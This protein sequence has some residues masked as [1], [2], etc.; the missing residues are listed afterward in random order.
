MT[1]A[2]FIAGAVV[3]CIVVDFVQELLREFDKGQRK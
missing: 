1:I 3:V 2:V